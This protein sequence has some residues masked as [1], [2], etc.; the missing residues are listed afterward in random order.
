M[1]SKLPLTFRLIISL[2]ARSLTLCPKRNFCVLKMKLS[3]QTNA[4]R[5]SRLGAT[6]NLFEYARLKCEGLLKPTS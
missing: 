1:K 3:I 4:S 5:L 6:P 2:R